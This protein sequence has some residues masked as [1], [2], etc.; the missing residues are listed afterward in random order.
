MTNIKEPAG[1]KG[2]LDIKR[3]VVDIKG[4]IDAMGAVDTNWAIGSETLVDVENLVVICYRYH[5]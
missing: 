4:E 2:I 5:Y 1:K 3:V